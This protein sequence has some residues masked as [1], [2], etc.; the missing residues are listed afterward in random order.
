MR[1]GTFQS[2]S[3][4]VSSVLEQQRQMSTLQTQATSGR[5]DTRLSD[6]GASA[7]RLLDVG[8][9]KNAILAAMDTLNGLGRTLDAT[10]EALGNLQDIAQRGR[11]M[12]VQAMGV[13]NPKVDLYQVA[14]QARAMLDD[15]LNV[16]NRQ[17]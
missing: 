12:L 3:S 7:G 16:L 14:A 17:S 10:D 4:R 9:E 1:I 2:L 13:T 11:A 15:A 5:R 6:V 8:S